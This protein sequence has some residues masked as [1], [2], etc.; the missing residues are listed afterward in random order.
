[1]SYDEALAARVEK[2]LR[3]HQAVTTKRMFGGLTFMLGDKMCCGIVKDELMVRVGPERFEEALT[4]P[5][6][7]PMDFTGRP[8]KGF[9]YVGQ[10]GLRRSA[11]L[12]QWIKLGVDFV[13]SLQSPKRK[14][15]ARKKASSRRQ[16]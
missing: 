6:A 7:R 4:R 15:A 16:R 9:I 3:R 10:P 11:A 13:S 2:A 8:M 1:M 14:K 12:E 5:G